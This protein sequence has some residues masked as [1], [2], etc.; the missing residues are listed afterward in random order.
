MADAEMAELNSHKAHADVA[1]YAMD[2]AV[3]APPEPAPAGQ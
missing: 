1:A 2:R 3:G